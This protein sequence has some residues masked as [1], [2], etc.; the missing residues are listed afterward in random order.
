M[1][2]PNI[3]LLFP[4]QHRGDYMPFSPEIFSQIGLPYLDLEMPNMKE[5]IARGTS[6]LNCVTP[7][8]ICA[9][10]RACLATGSRYEYCGVK[11]NSIDFPTQKKTMYQALRDVGYEVMGSGKF[12]LHK[13]TNYWGKEGWVESLDKIGFTRGI[14]N[15]GKYDAIIGEMSFSSTESDPGGSIQNWI[16]IETEHER[17]PYM[18][19]L[20]QKGKAHYHLED[21][22]RRYANPRDIKFTELDE[23]DYC[24][25]W[26]T[27][28]TLKLLEERDHEK[29]WFMQVNFSGPHDPWDI[30]EEMYEIVKHKKFPNT[31]DGDMSMLEIDSEIKKH[32]IAMI[33][34]IDRNIGKIL[35][36]LKADGE[37]ENTLVIYASDH[38]EMLGD[39]NRFGKA[40]WYRQSIHVPLVL[41]GLSTTSGVVHDSPVELQDLT[42]TILD[43]AGGSL[44]SKDS[45]SLKGMATGREQSIRTYQYSALADWKTYKD[46]KYKLVMHKDKP[47]LYDLKEDVD[48]LHDIAKEAPEICKE[49]M[50]KIENIGE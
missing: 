3:L 24:D 36:K 50:K 43:F 30:R 22:K 31:I 47:L 44:S 19:Y 8:P 25:N 23:D 29:P 33:E 45:K 48:E 21:F 37:F 2:K 32:Y 14:D 12:D 4:D 28:N 10:A 34:N 6:F 46:E 11:D 27:E 41:S 35:E 18:N 9:P 38:G 1:K 13:G 5:L 17:G 20:H 39:H 42:S 15:E 40:V 16:D 26:I 7:S 49:Y